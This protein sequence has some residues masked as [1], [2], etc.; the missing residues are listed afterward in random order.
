MWWRGA[1]LMKRPALSEDSFLKHLFSPKKN[2]LP[3]G[4]RKRPL[5]FSKGRSK[6]RVASYNRMSAA[7][8]EVLKRS[9]LRDAYLKGEATLPSAKR[10]LRDTAVALGFAKPL[11]Q[12]A[13]TTRIHQP[14]QETLDGLVAQHVA[15]TLAQ[16][17]KLVSHK[18]YY[19]VPFLPSATKVEVLKWDASKIRAYGGH[20]E[21]EY[22]ARDTDDELV[23]IDG[24]PFNPLWY[25]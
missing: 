22:L 24:A 8:Q 10:A 23:Y 5:A 13:T 11:R 2:P 3:T 17:G 4:L 18:F 1:T 12:R 21:P 25:K 9:G 20:S 15:R 6:A 19:R 14:R 16:A 7:N